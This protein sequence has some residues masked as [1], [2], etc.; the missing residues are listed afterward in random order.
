MLYI[1]NYIFLKSTVISPSYRKIAKRGL[2][3]CPNNK[4]SILVKKKTYKL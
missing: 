4:F 2:I 3:F 1:F